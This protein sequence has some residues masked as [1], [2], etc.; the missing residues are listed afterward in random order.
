MTDKVKCPVCGKTKI[1]VSMVKNEQNKWFCSSSCRHKWE[2]PVTSKPIIPKPLSPLKL[3]YLSKVNF[4]YLMKTQWLDPEDLQKLQLTALQQIMQHAIT[5]TKYYEDYTIPRSLD[6]LKD[7]PILTKKDIKT[8]FGQLKAERFPSVRKWTGG[9]SEQV[10]ILSN[11]DFTA[12]YAGKH[13]F[14]SWY[15]E[16]GKEACLWGAGELGFSQT[17]NR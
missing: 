6:D 10:V 13:R 4:K 8:K 7:Y 5:R 16:R 1:R 3:D 11:A 2:Q 14:E 17:T 12:L 15:P 9:T